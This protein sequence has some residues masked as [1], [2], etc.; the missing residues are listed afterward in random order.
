VG[1]FLGGGG[2]W[3]GKFSHFDNKN[4]KKSSARST[5]G[6][7]A[8]KICKS[9]HVL[10]KKKSESPYLDNEFPKVAKTRQGSLKKHKIP[11]CWLTCS[12]MGLIPLVD[13][14]YQFIHKTT[15]KEKNNHGWNLLVTNKIFRR[16]SSHG[17]AG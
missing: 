3:V 1:I 4:N 11:L 9:H 15:V 2:R 6:G 12:Q 13:E 7:L 5:K 17:A 16:G 14:H 8:E 10:E